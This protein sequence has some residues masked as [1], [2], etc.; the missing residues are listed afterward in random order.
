MKLKLAKP[1]EGRLVRDPRGM[2]A[3]SLDGTII[4]NSSF[5]NRR[6]NDGDIIVEEIEAENNKSKK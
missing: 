3:V 1:V 6:V 5:W 4:R 2:R